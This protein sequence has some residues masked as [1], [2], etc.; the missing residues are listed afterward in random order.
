MLA[1]FIFI[2]IYIYSRPLSPHFPV[3]PLAGNTLHLPQPGAGSRAPKMP[4]HIRGTHTHTLCHT[5][6]HRLVSIIN[7]LARQEACAAAAHRKAGMEWRGRSLLGVQDLAY[8]IIMSRAFSC[9]DD[10]DADDDYSNTNTPDDGSTQP[11]PSAAHPP[12]RWLRDDGDDD[13]SM[14]GLRLPLSLRMIDGLCG[15]QFLLLL[16]CPGPGLHPTHTLPCSFHVVLHF[17]VCAPSSDTARELR[18]KSPY[19]YISHIV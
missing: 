6:L 16:P 4:S 2:F 1:G 15:T 7:R 11:F 5:L 14:L 8:L 19:I 17:F 18:N 3:T 12:P 9:S 13:G 10:A